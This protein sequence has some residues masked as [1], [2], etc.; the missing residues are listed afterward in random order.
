MR[1]KQLV[2]LDGEP[3]SYLILWEENTTCHDIGQKYTN[4]VVSNFRSGNVS[5]DG[6]PD[7]RTTNDNTLNAVWKKNMSKISVWGS[8][9][10]ESISGKHLWLKSLRELLTIINNKGVIVFI[11]EFTCF[12]Y[13]QCFISWI[14]IRIMICDCTSNFW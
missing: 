2:L 10:G 5:F 7:T 8:V 12:A 11:I 6:Y 14:R 4:Y 13:N 9:K 1:K 3:L